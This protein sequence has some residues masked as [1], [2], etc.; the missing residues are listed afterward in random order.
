MSAEARRPLPAVLRALA[1]AS[2]V[3]FMASV[4]MASGSRSAA[5]PDGGAGDAGPEKH[6]AAMRAAPEPTYFPATK[7]GVMPHFKLPHSFDDGPNHQVSDP[8]PKQ[9]QK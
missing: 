6:G 5:A 4:A 2:A 1:L 7:S 8:A 9:G 3:L